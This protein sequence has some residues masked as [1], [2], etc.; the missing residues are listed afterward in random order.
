M[1]SLRHGL[2][3]ALCVL[4]CGHDKILRPPEPVPIYPDPDSPQNAVLIY[5]TAW[6]RRDSVAVMA[7]LDPS[8][9]GTSVDQTDPSS[10]TLLFSRHDEV[11]V[12]EGM[13]VDPEIINVVVDLRAQATWIRSAYES[14]PPGWA[15]IAI[16][17]P[18]VEVTTTVN[19]YVT[20]MILMEFKLKPT[21]IS[22]S[23]T[24]TTWAI[25]RW[26]EVRPSL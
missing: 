15:T 4:G 6:E 20:G 18:R 26:T 23:T 25:V 1:R 10:G 11:R 7:I 9:Q 17:N 2:L 16:P 3:L 5:K 24:D 22:G 21:P 14:D 13:L 19:T 12:V 8:Y